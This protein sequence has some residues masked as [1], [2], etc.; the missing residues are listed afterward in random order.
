MKL[1]FNGT[2]SMR[3]DLITDIKAASVAGFDCLEIWAA[4]LREFL[5]IKNLPED[6]QKE[7]RR[8]KPDKLKPFCNSRE[9]REMTVQKN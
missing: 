7:M 3:A 9:R 8:G 6:V 2:T 1:A 5:K 4:K